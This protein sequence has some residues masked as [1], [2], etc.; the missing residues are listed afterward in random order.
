VS[1]VRGTPLAAALLDR[2]RREG[3]IT[4][5]DYM[6]ACLYHPQFGYYAQPESRR[7][8]DFYT[9]PDVHPIF[10]RLL[11]RQ[12]AEMWEI[13][14]R[15]Q[16]FWAMEAGAGTGRLAAQ[17]LDFSARALPEFYSVLRYV[18]VETSASRQEA[19]AAA[20]APHRQ[21][22]RLLPVSRLPE[23]I[24]TGCIF[25]NELLDAFSVHRVMAG[26]GT[27]QEIFVAERNGWFAEELRPPSS[28]RI[29]EYFAAQGVALPEGHQAE[30]ALAACD[31]I[32][33]AGRRLERG[34][35]LTIDYG[36]EARELY[37][38]LH[39]RGTLLA[40]RE[41]RASEN[42]Y[43]APGMQDLTA[44]VSFTALDAWGRR[45]GLERTGLTS[46][47]RFLLSLGRSNEF[48]D[49]YDP[50]QSEADRLRAR[51]MLKTLIFPEGMGETFQ[52]FVQHKGVREEGSGLQLT[53][54]AEW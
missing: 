13:L 29:A 9:S 4:F 3:P 50:G 16:E 19:A 8:A 39:A 18:A 21:A 24:P 34:F 51:L 54:L 33:Q 22:A 45:A 35:V 53:G 32:E 23:P 26:K 14:G 46:Q 47:M 15:P 1:P 5:A 11:A 30:A 28:P 12:L 40:Y 43:D 37:N 41:H 36:H 20:L 6:Q 38:E 49:L 44:H 17:I 10:G 48:A 42:Y 52:V 7:F 25:S 27:L 31:W 2:I